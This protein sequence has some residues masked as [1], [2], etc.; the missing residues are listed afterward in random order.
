[1]RIS[2]VALRTDN[3]ALPEN[4]VRGPEPPSSNH[5]ERC[6]AAHRRR[7]SLRLHNQ[8]IGEFKQCG[9]SENPLRFPKWLLSAFS[10]ETESSMNLRIILQFVLGVKS[11]CASE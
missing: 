10:L 2:E 7:H 9:R 11:V 8:E 3:S 6:D 4:M 1:M 5:P